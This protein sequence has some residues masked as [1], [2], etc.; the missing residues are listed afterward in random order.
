[1]T[2]DA[3]TATGTKGTVSVGATNAS[4]V[5]V[6]NSAAALAMQGSATSALT[7][8]SG[9]NTTTINFLTPSVAGVIYQ[10]GNA[11]SSATYAICTSYQGSCA[12]AGAGYVQFVP[13]A[14]QSYN[15]SSPAVFINKQTAT[16]TDKILELQYN[17]A[18]V[19]AV[20]GNGNVTATGTYNT[21]TFTGNTL[22][23]GTAG[24][25]TVAS[26]ASQALNLTSNA[27]A[28]WQTSAGALTLTSAAAATWSTAAGVLT[29]QGAGGTTI[30]TANVSG[31]ATGN[32][33]IA[34]GNVTSG[35]FASGNITVDNGTSTGTT[36]TITI[37]RHECQRRDDRPGGHNDVYLRDGAGWQ[38]GWDGGA[39]QQRLDAQY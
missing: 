26:A 25:A 11:P 10:F 29:V 28:T 19:L 9:S 24:A 8:T 21:N 38:Y 16:A 33:S 2:V 27:G 12:A 7:V 32:V 37:R 15:S 4:A 30:N 18:D 6:G 14:A 34:T 5:N 31:A 17:A 1:M 13:A 36:G 22:T 35:A 20:Q 39:G 23:F 3:G